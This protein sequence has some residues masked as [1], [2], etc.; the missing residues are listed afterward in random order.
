MRC[1]QTLT[2]S[3]YSAIQPVSRLA[4]DMTDRMRDRNERSISIRD[5]TDDDLPDL[6]LPIKPHPLCD[7]AA[8][9][10]ACLKC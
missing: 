2:A 1:E 4:A 8:G 5:P 3:S 9:R 7:A 6:P 10:V